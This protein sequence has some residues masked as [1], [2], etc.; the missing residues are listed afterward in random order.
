MPYP[1]MNVWLTRRQPAV[2]GSLE[3][4]PRQHPSLSTVAL[5]VKRGQAEAFYLQASDGSEWVVKKFHQGMTLDRAYLDS[6]GALLPSAD[7]FVVG[8]TR[9]IL[10][11]ANV[12]VKG[13][14]ELV[15]WFDGTV[16]MPRIKGVDWAAMADRIRVG[17]GPE[18][19]ERQGWVV[20]LAS[21]I[22]ALEGAT[23]AHRDIS[24]GNVYFREPDLSPILI[25]WDS[26]YH[27]TL[28]RPPNTTAGTSG[29][30]APFVWTPAGIDA[31]QSWGPMSDRFALAV[32][33]AEFLGLEAGAPLAGEGGV[34]DQADIAARRGDSIDYLLGQLSAKA[35]AAAS[36]LQ[37]AIDADSFAAC[38]SPAEWV[39]VGAGRSPSQVK[40]PALSDMG[41]SDDDFLDQLARIQAPPVI[42]LAPGIS[43]LPVPE[44]LLPQV[45][46]VPP[47]RPAPE[48]PPDP[49]GSG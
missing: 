13:M 4:R 12:A 3:L 26:Y 39:A 45:V 40:P 21:A 6:I 43:E 23:G 35:P 34:L 5:S 18:L 27:P 9:R 42:R 8:R 46:D 29:Y 20:A 10:E 19:P 36:L 7:A 2:V 15:R 49:W 47:S 24:S 14:P 41:W 37:R 30:I 22:A 48:L 32:C 1:E 25:D 38:P 28:L 31:A 16:L 44:L 33:C 17:L 11:S